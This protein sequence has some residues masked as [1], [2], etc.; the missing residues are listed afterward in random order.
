[1]QLK[2]LKEAWD[3]LKGV[4][5]RYYT[6]TGFYALGDAYILSGKNPQYKNQV[7]LVE[8]RGKSQINH[9]EQTCPLSE[10]KIRPTVITNGDDG[11]CNLNRK[12]PVL[13]VEG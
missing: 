7:I 1:M 8:H 5:K 13:Q 3:L 9:W 12:A 11:Q 10:C 4:D 2:H 6:S